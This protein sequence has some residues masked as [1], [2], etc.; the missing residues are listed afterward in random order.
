MVFFGVFH[1][2]SRDNL[3]VIVSDGVFF[4]LIFYGGWL[5]L[6]TL[7]FSGKIYNIQFFALGSILNVGAKKGY[8]TV[9]PIRLDLIDPRSSFDIFQ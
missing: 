1:L 4:T 6:S 2:I 9:C 3:S 7:K 5:I 8:S